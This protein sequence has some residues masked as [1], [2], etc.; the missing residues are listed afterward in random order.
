MWGSGFSSQPPNQ[1]KFF[2]K[3]VLSKDLQNS[4]RERERDFPLDPP[5]HLMC[6]LLGALLPWFILNIPRQSKD[7]V[8]S[9]CHHGGDR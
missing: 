9:S 8:F 1:I 4:R 3:Q 5:S 7:C 6:F 2:F